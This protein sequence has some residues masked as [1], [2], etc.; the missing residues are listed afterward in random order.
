[1][2]NAYLGIISIGINRSVNQSIDGGSAGVME[3][4]L[5]CFRPCGP[6]GLFFSTQYESLHASGKQDATIDSESANK[7]TTSSQIHQNPSKCMKIHEK[8]MNHHQKLKS[9]NKNQLP[10]NRQ[11][12]STITIHHCHPQCEVLQT[13]PQHLPVS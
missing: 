4:V 8:S 10:K 5:E 13:P 12:G 3:V 7:A 1:M 9:L 2:C 11:P 6:N